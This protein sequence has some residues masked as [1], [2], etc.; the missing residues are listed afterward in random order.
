[1]HL[2]RLTSDVVRIG[3]G[4]EN[5][6]PTAHHWP[7]PEPAHVRNAIWRKLVSLDPP[8]NLLLVRQFNHPGRYLSNQPRWSS[9]SFLQV[10]KLASIAVTWVGSNM[11]S[12]SCIGPCPFHGDGLHL[13]LCIPDRLAQVVGTQSALLTSSSPTLFAIRGMRSQ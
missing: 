10:Q 12:H 9:F 5:D 3:G 8:H 13:P 11:R 1:M 7:H 4:G 6:S 2:E